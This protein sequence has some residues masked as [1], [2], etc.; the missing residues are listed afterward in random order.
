[1]E[2]VLIYFKWRKKVFIINI[3]NIVVYALNFD[4]EKKS[5]N[6]A[7]YAPRR[8]AM[9]GLAVRILECPATAYYTSRIKAMQGIIAYYALCTKAMQ[10][11]SA[12]FLFSYS[13]SW[14]VERI[15][16]IQGSSLGF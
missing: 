12:I 9:Q 11:V 4:S 10:G 1:M 5:S 14:R 16:E 2:H 13:L 15:L 8:K 6:S 3:F 7:H